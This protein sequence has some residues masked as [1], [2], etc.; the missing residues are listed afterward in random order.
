MSRSTIFSRNHPTLLLIK[1]RRLTSATGGF[2]SKNFAIFTRKDQCW[3]LFW[4]NELLKRDSNTCF[5][6]NIGKFPKNLFWTTFAYAC[7]WRDFRK[8]LIRAFSLENHFQNHPDLVI[9]E[10]IPVG[11][12]PE[13]SL[14]LT[15]T[16]YF[17]PRFPMFIINGYDRKANACSPW[18]SCF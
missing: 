18:T 8:L 2:L 14:N 5:P 15:P 6:V 3:S 10:K 16:L 17:E 1:K 13:P 4:M 7:F 11:F 12:K 9:L